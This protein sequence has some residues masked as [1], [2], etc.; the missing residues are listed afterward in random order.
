MMLLIVIVVVIGLQAVGLLLVVALLIIPPAAA[1]FWTDRL[2]LMLG[3]AAALGGLSGLLGAVASSTRPGLPAGAVIVLTAAGLFATSM[4]L[5]PQRG[6]IAQVARLGRL[7]A[8][9]AIDHLLRAMYE[10]LEIEGRAVEAGARVRIQN[11]GLAR[12]WTIAGRMLT[13]AAARLAGL[14][15]ADDGWLTLTDRGARAAIR[16]TRN[17]RMWEEYLVTHADVAASHVDWAADRVEHVLSARMVERLERA[18]QQRGELPEGVPPSVHEI[19][20]GPP[21]DAAAAPP[22]GAR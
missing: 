2:G 5:A 16:L 20:P 14:A 18:L 10:R 22:E 11:L 1:R 17:H 7:R 21:V 8:R 9:I 4:M 15:R 19:A 12:R 13:L 3:L 6:V